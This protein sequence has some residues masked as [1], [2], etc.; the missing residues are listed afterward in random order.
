MNIALVLGGYFI[1]TSSANSTLMLGRSGIVKN[2]F[3]TDVFR[4]LAIL[5]LADAA[6][7]VP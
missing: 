1:W 4:Y 7:G 5:A 2:P 6:E 3:S